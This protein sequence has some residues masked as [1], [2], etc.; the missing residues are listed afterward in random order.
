MVHP[1]VLLKENG[2]YASKR[3]GQNYLVYPETA[4]A[5]VRAAAVDPEDTVVEIGAGLGALT[6]LL[7]QRARKV[8]ALEIDRGVCAALARVM[9]QEGGAGAKVEI[10]QM[11]AMDFDWQNI[12]RESGPVKIVGNLPY[13]LSS[14]LLFNLLTN[15]GAWQSATLMLQSELAERL[16]ARPDTREYGRL[17]VLVQCFCRMQVKMTVAPHHFFPQPSVASQVFTLIPHSEPLVADALQPW[18]N[19]VVKAA[20]AQRRKTLLNS[21]NSALNITRAQLLEA[22]G[23]LGIDPNLRAETLNIKQLAYL[24]EGLRPFCGQEIN[25][26]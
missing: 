11:D 1:A 2:L 19:Q 16:N 5:I 17:S 25:K 13:A 18:F 21:L 26:Y 7:A 23:N 3:R 12:K 22:L 10:L 4:A 20:F 6:L 8:V 15:I 14:P 9:G 24:A